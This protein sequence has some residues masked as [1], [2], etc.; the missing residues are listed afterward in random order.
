M[1]ESSRAFISFKLLSQ[2]L[3][4]SKPVRLKSIL[5]ECSVVSCSLRSIDSVVSQVGHKRTTS[6]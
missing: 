4:S 1:Q 2:R 3:Q 6:I 5:E